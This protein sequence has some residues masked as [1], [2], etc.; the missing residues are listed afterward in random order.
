MYVLCPGVTA[1]HAPALSLV[2]VIT[3][4]S[5]KRK[6]WGEWERDR[7]TEAERDRP[8]E[9]HL[10]G[11]PGYCVLGETTPVIAITL[12]GTNTHIYIG[13]KQPQVDTHTIPFVKPHVNAGKYCFADVFSKIVSPYF[14]LPV[15]WQ[16][17]PHTKLILLRA[18]LQRQK[19]E[20]SDNRINLLNGI[21]VKSL[22]LFLMS[23]C[24]SPVFMHIW[25]HCTRIKFQICT[26]VHTH[27]HTQSCSYSRLPTLSEHN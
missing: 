15:G 16:A 20:H 22:T 10:S 7:A 24:L 19:S 9:W 18:P 21:Q 12:A 11:C 17:V 2:H 14:F 25:K 27:T 6:E 23:G 3:T 5:A 1:F 26:H 8:V 13:P 4:L